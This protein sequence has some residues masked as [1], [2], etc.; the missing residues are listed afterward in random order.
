MKTRFLIA[1]SFLPL[2]VVA[3]GCSAP[4]HF[5]IQGYETKKPASILVLPPKNETPQ[6]GVE[7]IVYPIILRT[8]GEKG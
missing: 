5:L 8:I 1:F 6:E 7:D 2:M 4:K 3:A